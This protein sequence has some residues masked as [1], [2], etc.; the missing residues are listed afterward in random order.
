MIDAKRDI[1]E[2]EVYLLTTRSGGTGEKG[3]EQMTM[4]REHTTRIRVIVS[5][6]CELRW[7]RRSS[8]EWSEG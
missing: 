4:K 1:Y 3:E 7:G 6:S 8:S 2:F 5:M